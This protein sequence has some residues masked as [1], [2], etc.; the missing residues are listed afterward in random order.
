MIN[1]IQTP[2][3]ETIGNCAEEMYF[4][5]LRARRENKK[6]IFL[7]PH[8]LK[9]FARFSKV[10]INRALQFVESEYRTKLPGIGL[11]EWAI[12]LFYSAVFCLRKYRMPRIGEKQL[13]QSKTPWA[14]QLTE[15]LPVALPD[16]KWKKAH[17]IR[18]KMGIPENSWFVCLHVREGGY[19]NQEGKRKTNRNARIK[20]YIQAIRYITDRGRWVIRMGD[21]TMTSLPAMDQV[22]DYPF[23]PFKSHLMDIY[24]IQECEFYIGSPSGIL[25]VA[26][27]FQKP[28]VMPNMDEWLLSYPHKPQDRGLLKQLYSTEKNQLFTPWDW[29][30]NATEIEKAIFTDKYKLIENTSDEIVRLVH[31]FMKGAPQTEKQLSWNAARAEAGKKIL[32]NM[33]MSAGERR[34]FTARIEG[35]R[36]SILVK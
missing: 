24:L 29:I 31:E 35:C 27:L 26:I 1:N 33:L 16:R 23:T 34:R 19:Y 25:D 12:S 11:A 15:Y 30:A 20:N 3:V 4:G 28:L 7:F 36:G 9:P 13:W 18:L 2:T 8:D 17:A 32:D 10:E 6:A 14:D 21:S 22:I 5:L